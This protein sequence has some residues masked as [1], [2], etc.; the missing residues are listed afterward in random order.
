M[1]EKVNLDVIYPRINMYLSEN[2][3]IVV[4]FRHSKLQKFSWGN[5]LQP[6]NNSYNN[7]G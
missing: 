4:Q 6:C 5:T 3:G 2:A 1:H 7:F